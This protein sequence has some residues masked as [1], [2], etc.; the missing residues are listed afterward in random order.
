MVLEQTDGNDSSPTM[1]LLHEAIHAEHLITNVVG[2]FNDGNTAVKDYDN[3]EEKKTIEEV[4]IVAK[5]IPFETSNRTDHYG[6]LRQVMRGV[7]SAL[8]S[9]RVARATIDK[10]RTP[11]SPSDARIINR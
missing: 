1:N 5:Q 4:N 2:T 9:P 7:T 3:M 6:P 11:F 10:T 8:L